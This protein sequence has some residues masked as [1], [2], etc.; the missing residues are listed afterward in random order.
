MCIRDRWK[1]EV[2]SVYQRLLSMVTGEA[3]DQ[4]KKEQ[5]QWVA[6]MCIRDRGNTMQWESRWPG[7]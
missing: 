7:Y 6:Q 2:D 5:A 3:Y 4:I 1:E